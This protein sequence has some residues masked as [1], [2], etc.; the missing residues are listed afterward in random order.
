MRSIKNLL[1]KNVCS[2]AGI[3]RKLRKIQFFNEKYKLLYEALFYL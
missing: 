1:T 2:L 3:G